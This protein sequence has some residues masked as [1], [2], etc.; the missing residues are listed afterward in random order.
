MNNFILTS[1]LYNNCIIWI[2][3]NIFL[4]IFYYF[5]NG[6]NLY[7]DNFFKTTTIK[8]IIIYNSINIYFK[9]INLILKI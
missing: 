6:I 3:I 5:N 2:F 9:E 1:I 4:N 8:I 7:I